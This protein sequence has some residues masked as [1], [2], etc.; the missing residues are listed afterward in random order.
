MT[1]YMIRYEAREE[2][3]EGDCSSYN[4]HARARIGAVVGEV[5]V[6][7]DTERTRNRMSMTLRTITCGAHCWAFQTSLDVMI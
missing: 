5:V 3:I 6:R 7:I 1:G 2:L 4:R